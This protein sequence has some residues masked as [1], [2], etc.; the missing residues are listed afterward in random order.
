M[1]PSIATPKAANSRLPS[2]SNVNKPVNETLRKGLLICGIIS[3][4]LYVAM[5][6]FIP[7]YWKEYSVVTQ[8]VSEL[9]AIDAPTRPIWYPLGLFYAILL[10]AFGWGVWQSALQNR[11][12][13]IVGGLLIAQGVM[14]LFWPPMHLRGNEMTMTDT[15]HIAFA[16]VWLIMSLLI[17]GFSIAAFTRQFR[18]YT[19]VTLSLFIIF[20]VLTGTESPNVAKNLPTPMIGVWER[21]NI[22]LFMLW[23]MVLA[24]ILL[25]GEKNHCSIDKPLWKP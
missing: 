5:N 9:S 3:S 8:T 24:I 11:L 16:F 21:I 20:G 22:A 4:L 17:L 15:M 18:F 10:I 25:P 13:R 2:G 7:M 6:I 23:L 1:N 19:I 12:L 14:N